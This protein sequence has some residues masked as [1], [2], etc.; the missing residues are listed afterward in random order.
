M[1][2]EPDPKNDVLFSVGLVAFAAMA[3]LGSAL[4]LYTLLAALG[5]V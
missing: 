4:V 1:R 5:L 2:R 3:G